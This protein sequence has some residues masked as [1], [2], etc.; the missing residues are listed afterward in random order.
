[1]PVD[2]FA[3]TAEF[4]AH[5]PG[6]PAAAIE[7]IADE[8]RLDGRGSMLDVGCGTGHVCFRFSGRCRRI[9]GIDPSEAMLAEAASIA[10]AR[11]LS[12]F[13]F[14][15]LRAEDLP[16]DLGT[17]RLVTFGASFHRVARERVADVV[18]DMLEPGGGLALLFPSVPWSGESPWKTALRH[19]VEKWTGTALGGPFEP[20][21]NVIARSRFR[22]CDVRN[23]DEE[24]LWSASEIF[25]FLLSTSFC[26]R[27]VL[28]ARVDAFR[29]D[30]TTLLLEAQPDGRFHDR[31][32]TTVVLARKP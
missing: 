13:E 25:G 31:M 21:Q 16:A 4:Y 19:A 6:Y 20:S 28:G 1:V 18:Y 5:R 8:F 26:S 15:P 2:L 24:H 14:R 11:G 22:A 17:F 9:I 30:L 32:E 3:E 23:F 10:S 29:Q 27:S 12:G 7:W